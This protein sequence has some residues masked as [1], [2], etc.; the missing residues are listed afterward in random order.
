MQSEWKTL[1]GNA[2]GIEISSKTGTNK[3]QYRPA[4]D[5]VNYGEKRESRQEWWGQ[6][7]KTQASDKKG[8]IKLCHD[9]ILLFK[10]TYTFGKDY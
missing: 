9:T 2:Q 7:P 3:P 6:K 5:Q 8:L 4:L 1:E 10:T